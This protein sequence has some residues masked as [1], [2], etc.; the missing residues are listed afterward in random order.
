MSIN[1]ELIIEIKI[2]LKIIKIILKIIKIISHTLIFTLMVLITHALPFLLTLPWASPL[3][4]SLWSLCPDP[5]IIYFLQA[6]V[7]GE[8]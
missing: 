1:Y 8:V 7:A 4:S 2:I 5:L 6:P 3:E